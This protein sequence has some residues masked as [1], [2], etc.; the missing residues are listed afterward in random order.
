[1]VEVIARA[2]SVGTALWVCYLILFVYFHYWLG[3]MRHGAI[4]ANHLAV[5]LAEVQAPIIFHDQCGDTSAHTASEFHSG[6][7]PMQIK[8]LAM[9]VIDRIKG[10]NSDDVKE[11]LQLDQK[12]FNA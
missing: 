10:S 11:G 3:M 5:Q 7:S 4:H 6:P 8:A 1:M 2:A 12:I 9:E